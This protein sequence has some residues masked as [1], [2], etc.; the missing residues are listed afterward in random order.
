MSTIVKNKWLIAVI[1]LLLLANIGTLVFFWLN[2]PGANKPPQQDAAAEYI[3]RETGFDKQQEAQYRKLIEEHQSQVRQIRDS[4]RVAKDRFFK[5]VEQDN[6]SDSLKEALAKQASD[7][8]ATLDLT[9]LHHFEQV[10]A[11]CRPDQLKKFESIIGEAVKMMGPQGNNG[12][13]GPPPR[14]GERM[15]GPPPNG[16][17]GDRP[18]P[19]GENH[20]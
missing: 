20:P 19:P 14:D 17:E 5:L 6:T 2:R 13:P 4:I 18:P 8:T 12:R 7:L 10:K 11:I 9:T 1:I 15:D 16:P 3:I